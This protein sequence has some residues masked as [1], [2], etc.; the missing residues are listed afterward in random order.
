MSGDEHPVEQHRPD[1]L[2]LLNKVTLRYNKTEDRIR[3]DAQSGDGEVVAFWF[4]QRVCRELIKGFV[5]YFNK[6]SLTAAKA[7]PQN[8][9]AVQEFLHDKARGD[10]KP[11]APVRDSQIQVELVNK[12]QLRASRNRVQIE[13]PLPEKAKAVLVMKPMEARQWLGILHQQYVLAEWPLDIWP[14]WI[15]HQSQDGELPASSGQKIH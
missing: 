13:L 1:G 15:K 12:L 5:S 6:T 14:D 9:S 7:L 4:T 11:S 8:L 3:M 2:L 10:L